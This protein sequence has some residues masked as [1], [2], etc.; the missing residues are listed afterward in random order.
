[1]IITIYIYD[2]FHVFVSF[3]FRF[4]SK[5][6]NVL[7]DQSNSIALNVKNLGGLL[8]SLQDN[9]QRSDT[10]YGHATTHKLTNFRFNIR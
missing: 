9:N 3:R 7:S 10:A 6:T 5:N 8:H 1:M 4:S 2:I